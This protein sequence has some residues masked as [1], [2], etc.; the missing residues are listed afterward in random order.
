MVKAMQNEYPDGEEPTVTPTEQD[1]FDPHTHWENYWDYHPMTHG[2][3]FARWD[4]DTWDVVEVTAEDPESGRYYVERYQFEPQDVWADPDD[5]M[6]G[7][8]DAMG[9]ILDS[10]GESYTYPNGEGNPFLERVTYYVVGL[11]HETGSQRRGKRFEIDPWD[12][13]AYWGELGIDPGQ[14]EHLSDDERPESSE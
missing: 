4:G 10:L 9:R 13:E 3:T 14:M 5:P 11:I 6:T 12:V 7:F 1:S 2:G 8:S